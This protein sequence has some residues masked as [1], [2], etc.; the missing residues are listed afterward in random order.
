MYAI[1]KYALFSEYLPLLMMCQMMG[2]IVTNESHKC[3]VCGEDQARLPFIEEHRNNNSS[4][5]DKIPKSC[6]GFEADNNVFEFQCP[7]GFTGCVTKLIGAINTS[8]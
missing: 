5:I 8:L 7:K 3:Y 4:V 1:F 6:D 2:F